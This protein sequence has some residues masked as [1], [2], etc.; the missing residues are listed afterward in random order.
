M[1]R[2]IR[3]LLPDIGEINYLCPRTT[4]TDEMTYVSEECGKGEVSIATPD[5]EIN[6]IIIPCP[7]II[8]QSPILT[9]PDCCWLAGCVCLLF[10]VVF[11]REPKILARFCSVYAW[12]SV[13]IHKIRQS[14]GKHT[15]SDFWAWAEIVRHRLLGLRHMANNQIYTWR[16]AHAVQIEFQ[17]C[18]YIHICLWLL[19]A[20]QMLF[21]PVEKFAEPGQ[22]PSN[23]LL[24]FQDLS[25]VYS[26]CLAQLQQ[27]ETLKAILNSMRNWNLNRI[28]SSLD[29][30]KFWCFLSMF[31]K[32]DKQQAGEIFWQFL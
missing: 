23:H 9:F 16:Y 15:G 8:M 26:M 27:V 30:L 17:R 12:W 7:G 3:Q 13:H 20:L 29:S 32:V 24:F 31:H 1:S 2:L 28:S 25:A 18:L 14:M 19:P 6:F 11:A 10:V 5:E 4:Q 21:V 22:H